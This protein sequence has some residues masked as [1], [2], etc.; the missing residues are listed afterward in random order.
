[1]D[2]SVATLQT[3]T[4]VLLLL[5]VCV[6]DCAIVGWLAERPSAPRGPVSV[7]GRTPDSAEIR[8]APPDDV[9]GT[10]LAGYAVELREATR[11][12]WR[13]VAV[14]GPT[15]TSYTLAD[16]TPGAEYVVRIVATN[17]EGDG[18]PLTS[19]VIAVPKSTSQYSQ[20]ATYYYYCYYYSRLTASAEIQAVRG[21]Y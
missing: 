6:C 10:P 20:T 15:T 19:D 8:W 12:Y 3:A 7:S 14:V 18:T 11:S 13:R 17:D 2:N 16:L 1:M 9:G 5:C 4:H 21:W